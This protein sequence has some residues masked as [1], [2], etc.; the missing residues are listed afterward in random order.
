MIRDDKGFLADGTG[1]SSDAQEVSADSP[2]YVLPIPQSEIDANEN[3]I[4]NKY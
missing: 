4:Q 1:A 3:M 2:Y